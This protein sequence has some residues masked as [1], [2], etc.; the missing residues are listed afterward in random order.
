MPHSQAGGGRASRKRIG[1]DEESRKS[2]TGGER[3][4]VFTRTNFEAEPNGQNEDQE[5]QLQGKDR[6]D[7]GELP[8]VQG[9][10]LEEEREDHEDEPQQPDATA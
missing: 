5:Q 9:D 7:L 8:E 1:K 2:R 3:P 10:R 4:K 6:L